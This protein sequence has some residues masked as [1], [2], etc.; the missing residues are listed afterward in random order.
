MKYAVA[1]LSLHEFAFRSGSFEPGVVAEVEINVNHLSYFTVT[2]SAVANKRKGSICNACFSANLR[3]DPL[4]STNPL[5]F[6][7]FL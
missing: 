5:P 1:A 3:E 6:P 2:V 4:H 7:L